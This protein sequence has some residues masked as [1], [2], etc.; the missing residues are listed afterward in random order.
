MRLGQQAALH[1]GHE[2]D[3][4]GGAATAAEAVPE[5]NVSA[6]RAMPRDGC[7]IWA[8]LSTPPGSTSMPLASIPCRPGTR[9]GAIASILPPEMPRS[10]AI[11]P[12]PGPD[13]P[14]MIAPPRITQS[15]LIGPTILLR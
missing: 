2:S 4:R 7:S 6:F 15:K 5:S 9:P 11:A 14:E 3:D 8:W 1:L 13:R 10:A 12:P